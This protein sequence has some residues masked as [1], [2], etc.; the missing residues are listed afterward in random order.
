MAPVADGELVYPRGLMTNGD[1]QKPGNMA[2]AAA[3]GISDWA[4]AFVNGE[5]S[6]TT[7]VWRDEAYEDG[8]RLG[9]DGM[10]VIGGG[11]LLIL[12]CFL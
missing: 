5:A 10:P 1:V 3:D 2:A 8:P 9:L 12:F 7:G 4:K 6:V 11:L